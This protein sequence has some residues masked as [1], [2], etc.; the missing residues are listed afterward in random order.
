ME[1]AANFRSDRDVLGGYVIFYGE[2]VAGWAADLARPEAWAPGCIAVDDSGGEWETV[3][4][5][6][7][8]G[9]ANWVKTEQ[10][11]YS[12][13]VSHERSILTEFAR[14]P[15][16]NEL[17]FKPEKAE[18]EERLPF[19]DVVPDSGKLS[20]WAV[21][22]TGGYFG[23]AA[24]GRHLAKIY[25]KH[26][27]EFGFPTGGMLQNIALDML[28]SE[29][30]SGQ[31]AA[32]RARSGQVTGFFSELERLI[33]TALDAGVEPASFGSSEQMLWRANAGINF[34]EEAYL[35]FVEDRK[36]RS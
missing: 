21:P 8:N 9:A 23:G 2:E 11:P 29:E 27:Q 12:E 32:T 34:D 6:E 19:V 13:V 22:A 25:L 20:R 31:G 35:N 18:I 33:Q 1:Q 36:A 26:L 28:D 10:Q 14:D 3:G 17:S 5:D 15:M 7:Y 24:T 4:G 30:L 16:T